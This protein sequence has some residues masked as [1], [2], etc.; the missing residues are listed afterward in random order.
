MPPAKC[1]SGHSLMC[2]YCRVLA[3]LVSET[4]SSR[5]TITKLLNVF[6]K[7]TCFSK[8]YRERNDRA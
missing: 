4:A 3:V 7:K 1:V 2:F 8:C 6:A 5:I